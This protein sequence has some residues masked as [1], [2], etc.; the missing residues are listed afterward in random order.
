MAK[1]LS[2]RD[3]LKQSAAV[4]AAC[5]AGLGTIAGCREK[6]SRTAGE[7]PRA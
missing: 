5:A 3:V 6:R 4:A 2:R 7:V 1:N